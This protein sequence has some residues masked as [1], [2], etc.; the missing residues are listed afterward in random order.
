MNIEEQLNR[1][2]ERVSGGNLSLETTLRLAKHTIYM[3][4]RALDLRDR[5]IRDLQRK[6][7][8]MEEA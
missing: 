2:I 5:E 4:E 8:E 6:L 1:E 7:K 3:R